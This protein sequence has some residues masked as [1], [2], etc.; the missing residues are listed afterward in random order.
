MSTYTPIASQTLGGAVSSVT[1]S[2]LPQNYTDLIVVV[3]SATFSANS[4]FYVQYNGDT[5]TNYSSTVLTGD[6]SSASS[7]RTTS[8]NGAQIGASDGQSSSV[9]QTCIVQIQNYSNGATNKTAISRW[10]RSD[11]QVSAT[12]S[13]WRNTNPI[14]SIEIYGG[15]ANGTKNSN[16]QTGTT[17]T[18]YGVTAGNSSAKASGGNIVTT[19]GSY[20]YHAYTS[21]GTFIPSTALSADVL[22]VA[23]GGSGGGYFGG[24]GGAGGLLGFTSQSLTSATAYNC[25]VG[26]GGA[27]G[28][29][30]WTSGF[31]SQFGSLTAAIGGGNGAVGGGNPNRTARSGGSGGGGGTTIGTTTGGS[32]SPSG[33]GNAGGNGYTLS[34]YPAGGGGGAI[35]AGTTPANNSSDGGNG[36]AGS[37]AYSSWLS[38]TGTG[39]NVSST[40][41]IAGGGG[42]GCGSNN[43][44]PGT[45]GNGGGGNGGYAS[46]STGGT[47]VASTDGT[48]N[49]GGG[50]GGGGKSGASS[51]TASGGSGII[52]VRYAV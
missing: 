13:M 44:T 20:W 21:T 40:Y 42:G 18:I 14:T 51:T 17:I 41:Y 5:G 37:S 27:G 52:I 25:V 16:M 12:V 36:G 46:L 32:A 6:G 19:D 15:Y 11:A 23:G 33:Q 48:A 31:N 10:S 3:G 39:Q 26:A 22:I 45:G 7:S 49:T 9:P 35:T 34:N 30:I 4:S 29:N 24:G 43:P 50:G 28:N 2:S 38:A 47:I 8:A 1:F